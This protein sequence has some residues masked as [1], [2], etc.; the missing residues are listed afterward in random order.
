M[1]LN[2]ENYK[3]DKNAALIFPGFNG[4]RKVWKKF[5]PHSQVM[6]HFLCGFERKMH[7]C[8]K[9]VSI[10]L[11][12]PK[13]PHLSLYAHDHFSIFE[14]MNWQT[15]LPTPKY[16]RYVLPSHLNTIVYIHSH[17][18]TIRNNKSD[19]GM[20]KRITSSNNFTMFPYNIIYI[21]SGFF[22]QFPV[23]CLQIE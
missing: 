19:V 11:R 15:G 20:S 8:K 22:T 5:A 17:L 2:K 16:Y 6:Y 7:C 14:V 9:L 23:L 18:H 21:F 1:L 13:N 3:N 4:L 12:N 10:S